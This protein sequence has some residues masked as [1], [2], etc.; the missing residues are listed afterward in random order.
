MIV[1]HL[2]AEMV[3]VACVRIVHR[4]IG[5]GNRAVVER[6]RIR[7]TKSAARSL[8]ATSTTTF[9]GSNTPRGSVGV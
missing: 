2:G 4:L 3:V 7:H 1:V 9:V 6:F 8:G 5:N